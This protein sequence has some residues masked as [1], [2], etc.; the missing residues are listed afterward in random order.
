MNQ[1][2]LLKRYCDPC[3]MD[4]LSDDVLK[5]VLQTLCTSRLAKR[6]KDYTGMIRGHE[7]T[8]TIGADIM[9]AAFVCKLFNRAVREIAVDTARLLFA[10]TKD[11][12]RPGRAYDLYL[13]LQHPRNADLHLPRDGTDWDALSKQA[14]ATESSGPGSTHELVSHVAPSYTNFISTPEQ[15]FRGSDVLFH[16]QHHADAVRR[17]CLYEIFELLELHA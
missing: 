5:P 6:A 14:I 16:C 15:A 1:D 9:E 4:S 10:A 8:L 11:E 2:G 7:F 17:H 3:A 12:R 13:L